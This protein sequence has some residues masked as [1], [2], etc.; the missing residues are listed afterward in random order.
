MVVLFKIKKSVMKN[1][2]VSAKTR[3][4]LEKLYAL[5][6][7]QH[8]IAILYKVWKSAIKQFKKS[9]SCLTIIMSLI[10]YI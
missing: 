5:K 6:F 8:L 9:I 2:R 10:I 7:V 4:M 3:F 1:S